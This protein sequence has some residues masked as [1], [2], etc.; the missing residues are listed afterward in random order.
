M[1]QKEILTEENEEK[2]KNVLDSYIDLVKALLKTLLKFIKSMGFVLIQYL[3]LSWIYLGI[4][5]RW[6]FERAVILVLIGVIINANRGNQR[7]NQKPIA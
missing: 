6:G 5:D 4:Y 3:V 1:P 7:S 2:M